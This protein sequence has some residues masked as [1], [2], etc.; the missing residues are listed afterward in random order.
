MLYCHHKIICEGFGRFGFAVFDPPAEGFHKRGADVIYPEI[1]G[2]G[3]GALVLKEVELT[4]DKGLEVALA[5][6]AAPTAA[7][8]ADGNTAIV[9]AQL[10][11]PMR[12][13]PGE[14]ILCPDGEVSQ[15][16]LGKRR[17]R[18]R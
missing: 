18:W 14:K 8:V 11:R 2:Q 16:F 15:F 6:A 12:C 1:E 9:Q 17:C 13:P 3:I 10:L 4:L 5:A 7:L